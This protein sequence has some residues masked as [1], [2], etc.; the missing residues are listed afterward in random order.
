MATD[1]LRHAV[2]GLAGLVG[3]LF[4]P[5]LGAWLKLLFELLESNRP[6][7]RPVR[8]LSGLLLL[9]AVGLSAVWSFFLLGLVRSAADVRDFQAEAPIVGPTIQ[10]VLIGIAFW[11][12]YAAS[13]STLRSN[14][15]RR[16]SARTSTPW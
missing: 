15:G 10:G 4:F 11:A 2:S 1:Q 9:K 12:F 3:L 6:G 16:S 7:I 14:F 8:P 13:L 5:T